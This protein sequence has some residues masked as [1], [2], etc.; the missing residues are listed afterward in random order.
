MEIYVLLITLV[1][2]IFMFKFIA[3]VWKND[4]EAIR[5]YLINEYPECEVIKVELPNPNL[6]HISTGIF[7]ILPRYYEVNFRSGNMPS[8]IS[9]IAVRSISGKITLHENVLKY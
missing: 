2:C 8:L 5:N 9:K 3:L 4:E 6:I 1:I 7:R